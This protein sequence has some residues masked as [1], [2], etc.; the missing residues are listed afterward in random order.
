MSLFTKLF[1]RAAVNQVTGNFFD[2]L[3]GYQPVFTTFRGG[4]Y[5]ADLCRACIHAFATHCSKLKPAVL[6]ARKDLRVPLATQPNPWMDTTKFLYKTAT[7]LENETTAFLVPL[8]DEYYQR[9][10]GIYPVQPQRSEIVEKDGVAYVVFDFAGGRRGVIEF[11]RVG[12]VNKFFY[13][14]DFFG[15]GN[16]ALRPTL[17]LLDT[18]RQG[19]NNGIK[20]SAAIR[21][22]GRL[23]STLK[24][25]DIEEE[26]KRWNA[27][28]LSSDNNGGIALADG[29]YAD[30]KQ[31]ESKPY[32]ISPEQIKIIQDN[33]FNYFGCNSKILQNSFSP[34]EW[35]AYYEGKVE[36]FALQLSLVISNMLFTPEQKTRGN[37]V[38]F[39]SNRLQYASPETKLNVVTQ[40]IDRG[41]MSRNEGREVFNMEPIEGGDVFVIRAEYVDAAGRENGGENNA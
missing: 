2:T 13:R 18:Q 32:L 21:F 39:T 11:D 16:A 31:I 4:I 41:M 36:P 29:K 9:I 22:I 28:N 40:M 17:E 7:I 37:E 30:L 10:V 15:E 19:I 23:T 25:K 27:G 14:N 34:Q 20:Q 6:G 12:I 5:E 26:R 8:Y 38:Q 24:P 1:P 3:T 35:D 33:V